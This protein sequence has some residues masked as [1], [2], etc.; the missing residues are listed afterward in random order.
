MVLAN[1]SI[2]PLVVT[3]ELLVATGAAGGEVTVMVTVFEV[4]VFTVL[5]D[6][7][8]VITHV[9]RLLFERVEE[10]KVLEFVPLLVPF[11]FH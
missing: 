10:V 2:V 7:L 8:D 4:A 3:G 6:A 1:R 11:T 5:Q 9:T